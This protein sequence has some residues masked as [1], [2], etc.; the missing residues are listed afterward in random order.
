[1]ILMEHLDNSD[2]SIVVSFENKKQIY[3]WHATLVSDFATQAKE[4][5]PVYFSC[6]IPEEVQQDDLLMIYLWNKKS[7]VYVDDMEMRWISGAY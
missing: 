1:M 2:A 4:W 5:F 7:P 6:L 3:Y